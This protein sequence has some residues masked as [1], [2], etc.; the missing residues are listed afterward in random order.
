MRRA[1]LLAASVAVG[2]CFVSAASDAKTYNIKDKAEFTFLDIGPIVAPNAVKG[3]IVINDTGNGTPTLQS[4]VLTVKWSETL[5]DPAIDAVTG[6]ADSSVAID[7]ESTLGPAP[8]QTG[9]GSTTSIIHWGSITG[10]ASSGQIS[11]VTTCPG[12]CDESACEAVFGFEGTGSPPALTSSS[13]TLDPWIFTG[14]SADFTGPI[15]GTQFWLIPGSVL[16]AGTAFLKGGLVQVPAV[17]AWGAGALA[18]ALLAASAWRS[19]RR[20]R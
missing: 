14:G 12:G 18:F 16:F 6:V 17:G 10:W 4:L 19:R 5:V 11:C 9:A 2:L 3:L 7:F 8:N 20:R 1:R 15:A 13:Y